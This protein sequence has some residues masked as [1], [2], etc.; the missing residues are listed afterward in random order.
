MKHLS[1][2]WPL[3]DRVEMTPAEPAYG[4]F[5]RRVRA[6]VVDWIIIMLLLVTALFAAVSANSD[7]VGRV[8]GFTFVGV[9][10]LYEPLLVSF[11]GSTVGHYLST[12]I[13][14]YGDVFFGVV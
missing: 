1:C 10:L 5:S 6:F 2:E 11:T 13:R 4:R 14:K 8:L 3:A 9:W 12:P 7:R